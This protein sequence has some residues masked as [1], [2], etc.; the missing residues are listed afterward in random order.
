MADIESLR[1]QTFSTNLELAL[2]Q[3][4]PKLANY[5]MMEN[6]SGSNSHRFL[7]KLNK[8]DVREMTSSIEQV[9]LQALSYDVRW[10]HIP[11]PIVFQAPISELDLQQTNINPTGTIVQGAVAKLNREQDSRFLTAFFGTAYTGETGTTSTSFTAGQQIAGSSTGITIEKLRTAR[12]LLQEAEVDLDNEMPIIAISP[13]MENQLLALT[14]IG[15]VDFNETKTLVNGKV[16]NFMGFQF[17]VS[18][19]LPSDGTYVRCPVWVPSAMGCATWTDVK[20]NVRRLPNYTDQPYLIESI[21]RKQ[22][23][24]L[25]E[26]KTVELKAIE[27]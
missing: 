12:E 11:N 20:T 1:I 18:N 5:A 16:S 21:M 27:V 14:E 3:K 2:Q 22:W 10:V 23:T 4:Q 26:L 15:S 24:R 7:S 17:V 8:V 13:N 25:D 6:A 9:N 19:L